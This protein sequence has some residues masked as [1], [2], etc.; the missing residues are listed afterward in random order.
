MC[1]FTD[2]MP[3]ADNIEF[4]TDM[5]HQFPKVD[6]VTK[7]SL[8]EKLGV[9]EGDTLFEINGGQNFESC[10]EAV[11]L[12]F[13]KDTQKLPLK[14]KF[15]RRKAN[16]PLLIVMNCGMKEVLGDYSIMGYYLNDH[17]F[18]KN[19]D[20]SYRIQRL[21]EEDYIWCLVHKTA[22]NEYKV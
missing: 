11:K 8:W 19:D 13:N 17:L 22:E 7:G 12:L 21:N 16:M 9:K 3:T 6:E 10:E 2:Q 15:M 18:A 20:P 14:C 1:E 4:L 5:E